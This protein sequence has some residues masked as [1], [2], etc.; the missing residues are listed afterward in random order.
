VS[1][2]KPK[3]PAP[4]KKRKSKRAWEAPRIKTGQLFESSSLSCGKSNVMMEPCQ[5]I[6]QSS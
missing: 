2:A 5:Q 4:A 6:P 3:E 1:A